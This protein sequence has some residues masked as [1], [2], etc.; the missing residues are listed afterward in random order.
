MTDI[1]DHVQRTNDPFPNASLQFIKGGKGQMIWKKKRN[2]EWLWNAICS[3]AIHGPTSVRN[4][5]GSHCKNI[6]HCPKL[7]YLKLILIY[8]CTLF[9]I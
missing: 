8:I 6:L 1:P 4:L 3:S 9:L 7:I 5:C 2:S